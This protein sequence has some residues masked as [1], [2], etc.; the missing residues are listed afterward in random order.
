MN[1][2]IEALG[3]GTLR[4]RVGARSYELNHDGTPKIGAGKYP[5]GDCRRQGPA[6]VHQQRSS[7]IREERRERMSEQAKKAGFRSNSDMVK[8]QRAVSG[9][10]PK[11]AG[12][13]ATLKRDNPLCARK[14]QRNG[15]VTRK[16]N[17]ELA[18]GL[19]RRAGI[20]TLERGMP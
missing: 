5:E 8:A 3:K 15:R 17:Q 14:A 11:H 16:H 12:R 10:A 9:R 7:R 1:E 18:R 2:K 20:T 6:Y 4:V 19:A 13:T